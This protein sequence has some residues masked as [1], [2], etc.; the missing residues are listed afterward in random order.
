MQEIQYP[1]L[2][3]RNRQKQLRINWKGIFSCKFHDF[4]E[5]EK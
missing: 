4:I 3:L 5:K 2:S 1:Q